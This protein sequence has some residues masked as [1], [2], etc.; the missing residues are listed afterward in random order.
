MATVRQPAWAS[1]RTAEKLTCSAPTTTARRPTARGRATASCWSAPVVSTPA[2]RSPGTRPG[3]CGAAPGVPVASDDGRG[4]GHWPLSAAR[5]GR[6]GRRS[7]RPPTQRR[8]CR[9]G[10]R[11]RRLRLVDQATRVGRADEDAVEVAQPE[12]GVLGVAGD[13][14]GSCSRSTTTTR[15]APRRRSSIAALS[16]AGP[17]PTTRTS[18][19]AAGATSW[20]AASSRR[21]RPTPRRPQH[22]GGAVEALAAPGQ[23]P[24]AAAHPVEVERPGP[25]RRRRPVSS[26]ASP[27][28]SGTRWSRRP[29]TGGG[30]PRRGWAS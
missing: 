5:P 10:S 3:R 11:R 29:G 26:P 12:A 1:V 18:I 24:R 19:T 4:A 20:R 30:R 7:G 28:R 6:P 17:P 9:C 8:W 23:R 22:A 2:G 13:A 14:A 16:P 15:P 21:W 25:G 27:A